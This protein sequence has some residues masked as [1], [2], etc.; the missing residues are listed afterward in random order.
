MQQLTQAPRNNLT[1]VQVTALLVGD[2]V[3]VTAGLEL[4]DGNNVFVSDLST[5]L[6]SG[7]VERH[8][9]ATVHGLCKLVIEG[10]LAWGKDRVRPYMTLSNL[11]VSARFNMGVFVMTTPDTQR[12][13]DPISY[14]VNGYDL[15]FLLQAGPGDTYVATSGTTYLAAV[16]AVLA[17]SGVGGTLQIDG[18]SAASTLPNDMV[19]ALTPNVAI[20]YLGIIN[21]LLQA[22]NY[23]GLW[24]DENGNFRS[25]PYQVPSSRAAEWTLDTSNSSTSIVAPVRTLASDVWAAHNWWRFVRTPMTVRPVEGA[26]LY[27]VTNASTGRTSVAALGRTVRAAVQYLAAANQASLVAQGDA[28]VAADQAISRTFTI[29]LDPLPIAGHFDVLQFSDD[30]DT[31]KVQ[32]VSWVINLDGAPGQWVMEAVN[33]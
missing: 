27:T 7:S 17:A 30:G 4:L 26:G 8:N 33:S 11:G 9:F 2:G 12:G 25:G 15:L 24:C 28:I 6:V 21:D 19:W 10:A 5:N 14:S 29:N 1:A 13:E 16:Q 22:I 20:S 23:R 18:T 31:D 3:T 32:V